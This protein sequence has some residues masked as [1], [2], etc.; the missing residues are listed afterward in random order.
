[1]KPKYAQVN[2]DNGFVLS[3]TSQDASCANEDP[4][5]QQIKNLKSYI[6]QARDA[7]MFDEVSMLESNLR[8]LEEEFK[9]QKEQNMDLDEASY[10]NKPVSQVR[11]NKIQNYQLNGQYRKQPRLKSLT[12]LPMLW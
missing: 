5:V 8:M 7:N 3:S 4:V 11:D 2:H 12:H 10:S 1:M 9:R 6:Q